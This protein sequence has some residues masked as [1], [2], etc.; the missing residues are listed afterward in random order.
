MCTL[1]MPISSQGGVGLSSSVSRKIKKARFTVELQ[2]RMN[3]S[4]KL[5]GSE[6]GRRGHSFRTPLNFKPR[7]LCP[8]HKLIFV[9]MNCQISKLSQNQ[10]HRSS[11]LYLD[12]NTGASI[13]NLEGVELERTVL[14]CSLFIHY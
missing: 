9:L 7:P 5:R 3:L 14:A 12:R 1:G 2:Q 13:A 8:C 11:H 10:I 4:G 6:W